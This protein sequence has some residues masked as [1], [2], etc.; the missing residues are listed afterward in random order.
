MPGVEGIAALGGDEVARARVLGISETLRG[1]RI[2]SGNNQ[3]LE[4]SGRVWD[5]EIHFVVSKFMDF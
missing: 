2:D 5:V 3:R 1:L 4:W